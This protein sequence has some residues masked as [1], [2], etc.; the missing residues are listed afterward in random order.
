M[1][2]LDQLRPEDFE[3]LLGTSLAVEV[4]GGGL[5]CELTQVRRLP[6]HSLRALPPF[7]LILRGPR[8]RPFAQGT[9]ALRHPGHG[10]LDLFMVPVGPDGAGLCYEITFN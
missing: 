7:A 9:Y 6:P 10:R 2:Q 8:E 1:R 4:P 5:A 3:P